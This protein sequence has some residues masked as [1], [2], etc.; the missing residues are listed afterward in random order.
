MSETPVKQS[1]FISSDLPQ[2]NTEGANQ[3]PQQHLVM[4]DRDLQHIFQSTQDL[5]SEVATISTAFSAVGTDHA[6]LSHLAYAD[7]GHTGFMPAF[8]AWANKGTSAIGAT[9]AT[10]DGFL[11]ATIVTGGATSTGYVAGFTDSSNPPT[12]LRALASCTQ[13]AGVDW[14]QNNSFNMPVKKDDYYLTTINTVNGTAP[15]VQFYW[16]PAG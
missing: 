14:A 5:M 13:A 4:V 15:S 6:K 10:A 11:I 7:A 9:K 12:T 2:V 16:L 3:D 1:N 8:G